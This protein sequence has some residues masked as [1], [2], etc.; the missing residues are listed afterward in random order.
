[1]AARWRE[2][3]EGLTPRRQPQHRPVRLQHRGYDSWQGCLTSVRSNCDSRRVALESRAAA[4]G[5]FFQTQLDVRTTCDGESGNVDSV[6][7]EQSSSQVVR[8]GT[9]QLRINCSH[10]GS[11]LQ[12]MLWYRH[13]QGSRSMSL[14]GHSV[15]LADPVYE[16]RF[17]DRF[18]LKRDDVLR[19]SLIILTASPSDSAVYF[20]AASTH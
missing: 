15:L 4:D 1:M 19:G 17:K 16:G 13:K 11:N 14:I 5:P 18:Q 2:G 8:D 12:T 3:E 20:C 6:T 9:A 7:F 10:D